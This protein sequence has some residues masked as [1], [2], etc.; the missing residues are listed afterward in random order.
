MR[1]LDQPSVACASLLLASTLSGCAYVTEGSKLGPITP[2]AN[3]MRPMIEH[4]VGDFSFTLEGGK[5]VTSNFAGVLINQNV[6]NAWQDKHY[7]RD[8]EAVEQGA[9]N[10]QG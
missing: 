3:T 5:M 8:H 2:P 10:R 7:I 6:M 1:N 9:F 4:T